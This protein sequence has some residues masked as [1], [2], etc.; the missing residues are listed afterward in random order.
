MS[1]CTIQV[2]EKTS[3]FEFSIKRNHVLSAKKN[4]SGS[5]NSGPEE[6]TQR[7]KILRIKA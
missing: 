5:Q 3:K 2:S 1:N 7:G 4:E 6:F